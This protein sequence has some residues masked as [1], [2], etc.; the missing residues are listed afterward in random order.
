MGLREDLKK[1]A[2]EL[3]KQ[4]KSEGSEEAAKELTGNNKNYQLL[5]KQLYGYDTLFAKM[6]KVPEKGE[7][8]FSGMGTINKKIGELVDKLVLDVDRTVTREKNK[9]KKSQ[10]YRH[11]KVYIA[12][13]KLFVPA[14]A[15]Q[16]KLDLEKQKIA[17]EEQ[18]KGAKLVESKARSIL[19]ALRQLG[20]NLE[21]GIAYGAKFCKEVNANPKPEEW[22]RVNTDYG[23]RKV[24]TPL[25][26]IVK[27]C[28]TSLQE[29]EEFS[30]IRRS[31]INEAEVAMNPAVYKQ[32]KILRELL[33]AD[34][35]KIIALGKPKGKDAFDGN[36]GFLADK[37][38]AHLPSDA[39]AE[40]VR[41]A[42]KRVATMLK[43][44]V[45]PLAEK[46]K[47]F[48]F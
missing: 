36:I 45:A 43:T 8:Y 39:T 2:A 17:K 14:I 29:L 34:G 16:T 32:I 27:Y 25:T 33:K 7:N 28:Y 40:E 24:S 35:E 15:Q 4:L 19:L 48:G 20:T 22:K 10:M 31:N 9:N 12:E 46:L 1:A 26:N 44:E 5:E 13:L 11:L 47:Q 6:E 30:K 21:V 41:R 18:H 42:V 37:D 23:L 38:E 3:E